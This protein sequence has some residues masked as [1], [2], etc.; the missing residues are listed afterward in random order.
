MGEQRAWPDRYEVSRRGTPD[1]ASSRYLVLDL[2]N[3]FHARVAAA[4]FVRNQRQWGSQVLADEIDAALKETQ[5]AF[6]AIIEAR[7]ARLK[8]DVKKKSRSS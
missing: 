2:V 1:P 6:V 4:N 8:K 7:N 5:P 3:D